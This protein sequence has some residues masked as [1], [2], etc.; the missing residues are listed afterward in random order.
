M[1]LLQKLSIYNAVNNIT[2]NSHKESN[3]SCVRKSL[4]LDSE[5]SF[6][7]V[8]HIE[9]V[10]T[11]SSVY[12]SLCVR[13]CKLHHSFNLQCER[14]ISRWTFQALLKDWK[15]SYTFKNSVAILYYGCTISA[16]LR[17][18]EKHLFRSMDAQIN[19][20]IYLHLQETGCK[21]PHSHQ[22]VL[23][24]AMTTISLSGIILCVQMSFVAPHHKLLVRPGLFHSDCSKVIWSGKSFQRTWHVPLHVFIYCSLFL[25]SK[26]KSF[27]IST[28]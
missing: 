24:R 22:P 10:D 12:P 14:L 13:I 28:G 18:R 3:T 27:I 2:L 17:G 11:L 8:A 1:I 7:C 5:L 25:T 21:P 16:G 23:F 15:A 26:I 4:Q 9:Q 19:C 20:H 6:R